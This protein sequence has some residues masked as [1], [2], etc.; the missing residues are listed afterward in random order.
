MEMIVPD[1]EQKGLGQLVYN[2]GGTWT[3]KYDGFEYH[4]E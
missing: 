4:F 1:L 2:E 3:F